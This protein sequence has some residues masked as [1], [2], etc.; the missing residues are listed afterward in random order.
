M[1]RSSL[2]IAAACLAIAW[3]LL[4]FPGK[5]LADNDAAGDIL[6]YNRTIKMDWEGFAPPQY[7]PHLNAGT[8]NV[9]NLSTGFYPPFLMALL[10]ESA[11]IN[12]FIVAHLLI[13][14]FGM[15]SWA[16]AAGLDETGAT[17]AAIV[18]AMSAV[19]PA[20]ML[21]GHLSMIAVLGWAPVVLGRL[22]YLVRERTIGGAVGL[23][24]AGA[25]MILGGHAQWIYIVGW[26]GVFVALTSAGRGKFE[27]MVGILAAA[28]GA[29]LLAAVQLLPAMEL[30]GHTAR[31]H[32][33]PA[34]EQLPIWVTREDAAGLVAPYLPALGDFPWETDWGLG[35]AGL[36]LWFAGVWHARRE[37]RTWVFVGLSAAALLIA[38][39]PATPAHA[40][41]RALV[42]LY[43][44]MR[45][46]PRLLLLFALTAPLLAARGYAAL[47][48]GRGRAAAL[49]AIAVLVGL[50]S[51]RDD[52]ELSFCFF[53]I[54]AAATAA[55]WR[56]PAVLVGILA[57]EMTFNASLTVWVAPPKQAWRFDLPHD[58]RVYDTVSYP[59]NEPLLS[60]HESI[61]GTT[62][63]VLEDYLRFTNAVWND[64]R[65]LLPGTFPYP[66]SEIRRR[67]LFDLLGIKYVVTKENLEGRGFTL[68]QKHG[69]SVFV[70]RNDQAMAG[71]FLVS[72][73]ALGPAFDVSE[74]ASG[75]GDV[76]VLSR[77]PGRLALKCAV[78]KPSLLAINEIRW[79][80]WKATVDGAPAE[81][82]PAWLA[83]MAI[84][85][86]PGEHRVELRY[87]LDS[88]R[89][90]TWISLAAWIALAAWAARRRL[91]PSAS[92]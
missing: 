79:P 63:Q 32:G 10:P 67:A 44:Q 69:E 25:M 23:A 90:G 70:Y 4:V 41:A 81:I 46:I 92:A 47:A 19:W 38:L 68:L 51:L 26:L 15:R 59:F 43:D 22:E 35:V 3:K 80:G 49:G 78:T 8:P 1:H 6:P 13:G 31:M 74:L 45:A 75:R 7:N 53:T 34:W 17:V 12:L 65:P 37:T 73:G 66:V 87:D 11:A 5:T 62:A 82:L 48:E 28:I 42:P 84:E 64:H 14:A 36:V 54:A 2:L 71:A 16:R 20:R 77:G 27:A 86:E 50:V 55:F 18:Y 33:V 39:G 58:G 85:L 30:L 9:G 56:K 60:G 24:A 89:R 52:P 88:Y 83:L 72:R 61:H 76:T 21:A 91:R 57:A 40:A 29:A